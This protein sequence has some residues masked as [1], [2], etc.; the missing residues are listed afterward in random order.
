M[1]TEERNVK[2]LETL[3]MANKIKY[4]LNNIVWERQEGQE[5]HFDNLPKAEQVALI[6][7]Y[8]DASCLENAIDSY[9]HWFINK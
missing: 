2:I 1:T 5:D 3:E 4:T 8:N 7:I 6:G 9:R